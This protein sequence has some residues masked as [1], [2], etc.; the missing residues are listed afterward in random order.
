M[1][2]RAILLVLVTLS[3]AAATAAREAPARRTANN[4][5]VVL[6]DVPEV[7]AELAA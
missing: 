7:P 4:G 5:N 2:H 1:A 3:L 6:E